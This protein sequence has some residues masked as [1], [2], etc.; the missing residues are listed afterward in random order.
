[1][2]KL[3]SSPH[4]HSGAL[5]AKVMLWVM[6]AI[7][8]ALLAM[9]YYFGYGVLIQALLALSFA[10]VL[11]VGVSLCRHKPAFFY[12]K[13]FSGSLTALILAIAI[14]PYAP[15]WVVLIGVAMAILVAKHTYGGLG[16]NLFNPAMV[17][18]VVLLVSFPLQMTTWLPPVALLP[19]PLSFS[20]GWQWIFYGETQGVSLHNIVASIDG[21]TQATPLDSLRTARTHGEQITYAL[22]RSPLFFSVGEYSFAKGWTQVNLCFLLGGLF[23]VIKR[24]IHWQIPVALLVTFGLLC[25]VNAL[26]DPESPTPLWQLLSGATMFG[27]FFIATDPVTASITPKGKVIFGALIGFLLYLIRYYGGYPDAIAFAVLLANMCVPLIDYYTR[28]RSMGRWRN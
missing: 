5:T 9:V 7:L 4:T 13:D 22:H 19:E 24:L 16:Q 6:V 20:H 21:L 23:L 25:G 14:P 3:T 1:M 18:Y 12:V 27:A 26:I 2:F 10:F 11:E 17:G 28:P 8:P 15:F